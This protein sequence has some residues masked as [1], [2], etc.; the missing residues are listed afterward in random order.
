MTDITMSPLAGD[1]TGFTA[2]GARYGRRRDLGASVRST[3]AA[4]TREA[5]RLTV[6]VAMTLLGLALLLGGVYGA[7]EFGRAGVTVAVDGYAA[8]TDWICDGLAAFGRLPEPR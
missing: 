2:P 7:Y 1:L 3:L 4:A 6:Q 8:V 5:L